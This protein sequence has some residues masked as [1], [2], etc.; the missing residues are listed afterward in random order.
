MLHILNI[1]KFYNKPITNDIVNKN[2]FF[3]IEN[4]KVNFKSEDGFIVHTKT[5]FNVDLVKQ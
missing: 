3:T 1:P 5:N 4:E 2:F